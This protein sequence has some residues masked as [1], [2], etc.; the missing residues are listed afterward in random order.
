M[1]TKNKDKKHLCLKVHTGRLRSLLMRSTKD[2]L[3]G[4]VAWANP[5]TSWVPGSGAGGGGAPASELG[6]GAGGG[7]VTTRRSWLAR[8]LQKIIGRN[9]EG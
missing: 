6:S 4:G 5:L 2:G 7:G 8:N 9:R 3:F 1:D